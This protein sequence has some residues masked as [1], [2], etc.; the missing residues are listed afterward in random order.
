MQAWHHD[1]VVWTR[2]EALAEIEKA[3]LVEL[4]ERQ[5]VVAAGV[6]GD[7]GFLERVMRQ[8]SDAKVSS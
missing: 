5:A 4:P 2:E 6:E 3:H 7:E 1:R 8:A